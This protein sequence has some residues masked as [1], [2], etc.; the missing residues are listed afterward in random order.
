MSTGHHGRSG[1]LGARWVQ[2][3]LPWRER[4]SCQVTP[5]RFQD[6]YSDCVDLKNIPYQDLKISKNSF[7]DFLNSRT[8]QNI[9]KEGGYTVISHTILSMQEVE[10]YFAEPFFTPG[11]GKMLSRAMGIWLTTYSLLPWIRPLGGRGRV[12]QERLHQTRVF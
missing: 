6:C 11:G 3:L 7:V 12:H 1:R 9:G 10:T 4:S 5:L 8:N 2:L